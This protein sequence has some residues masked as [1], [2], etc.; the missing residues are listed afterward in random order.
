M[1]NVSYWSFGAMNQFMIAIPW[2]ADGSQTGPYIWANKGSAAIGNVLEKPVNSPGGRVGSVV[3]QFLMVGDVY[4]DILE[5]IATG[6]GTK[7]SFTTGLSHLPMLASGSV[8]D[9]AGKFGGTFNQ[10]AI[11]GSG[12]LQP[13]SLPGSLATL[14]DFY[15]SD[16]SYLY[17]LFALTTP[18]NPGQAA[19]T[20]I[21][22]NT[23]TLASSAASYTYT[24]GVA[25]W[26]WSTGPFAFGSMVT[27][28]VTFVPSSFST[29]IT[30]GSTA[31][32]VP[33]FGS[34]TV[35][36]LYDFKFNGTYQQSILAVAY[37]TDPGKTAAFTSIAVNGVTRTSA[38]ATY[39][40][41]LGIATWMW[42]AGA[43]GIADGGSYPVHFAGGSWSG[44]NLVAGHYNTTNTLTHDSSDFYGYAAANIGYGAGFGSIATT[45]T[46][47]GYSAVYG[48][49]SVEVA[50]GSSINYDTGDIVLVLS[51]APPAGDAIYAKYTLAAPYRVH[52]SAIGD[53]TNWPI[54]LTAAAI[55]AQ[56]GYEDLDAEFGSVMFIAGYP[57]YA[58]IFQRSGIQRAQYVGGQVVFNFGAVSR[59]RG[60]VTKGAACQVGT[61]VY[62][63]SQDGFFVTDG[64]AVQPIGTDQDNEAG[65]DDWFWSNVNL[66][67]IDNIR[68]G[69]QSSTRCMYWAIPTGANVYPD[70]QLIYNPQANRW[71]R[72][73]ISC[74][75]VWTDDDGS[76]VESKKLRL[77]LFTTGFQYSVLTGP[78]LNGYAETIDIIS[79]DGMK[80]FTA[81]AMPN[82]AAL[83]TPQVT[84]GVRDS[85]Q[86][87]VIYSGP[88]APDPFARIAPFMVE[89]RYTR[90]RVSAAQAT[91]NNGVALDMTP[92]SG[93]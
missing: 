27:Y 23:V 47:T 62:F 57:L 64:T 38:S 3:G 50:G 89:G 76:T 56:S 92:T 41:S 74:Q 77:G 86:D 10:G 22:A 65:I 85:P 91:S 33:G 63:L 88:V 39:S 32:S 73:Q 40:Y 66:A 79:S 36:L 55:A 87:P 42:T 84:M 34:G 37:P 48:A 90:A 5:L 21:T 59:N 78:T 4:Q 58:V 15:G 45:L 44:G 6:D 93:V 68:C 80:Q 26:K 61:S 18:N 24:G 9:Q 20:S 72:A 7:A 71:T 14:A 46:I 29:S 12:T 53:P 82:C 25:T 83:D 11:S 1:K 43:F 81:G 54:P 51:G 28:P 30:G 60:L 75:I 49:G 35:Q 13:P 70:T 69:Y 19:F 8:Y 17:S 67:A 2:S 52:W 31:V 16:G